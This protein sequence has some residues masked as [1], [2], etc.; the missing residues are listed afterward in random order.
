MIYD[1]DQNRVTIRNVQLNNI[2]ELTQ[3]IKKL[4]YKINKDYEFEYLA[5]TYSSSTKDYV[6]D[7]CVFIY[8]EK[9]AGDHRLKTLL[10]EYMV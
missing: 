3:E 8:N 6:I 10:V 4:G 5:Y 2:T 7:A 1:K 9:L